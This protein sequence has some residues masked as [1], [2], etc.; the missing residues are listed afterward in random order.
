VITDNQQYAYTANFVSGTISSY[1]L[2]ANGSVA[3][4]SG[5]EA[6]QGLKSEPTDLAFSSGSHYLYNLLRGT[7]GVSAFVVK[8]NGSLGEIGVFG[9]GGGLPVANGASG[10]AAY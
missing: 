8:E 6:F 7:G 3:L 2:S 9:V 5:S 10:L 1:R 4:I